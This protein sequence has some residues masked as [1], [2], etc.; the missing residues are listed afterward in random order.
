MCRPSENGSKVQIKMM[1]DFFSF[2]QLSPE[3]IKTAV[4]CYD[5]R[6]R[7]MLFMAN[8]TS[9]IQELNL[10]DNFLFRKVMGDTEI[11]RR[12]LEKILNVPI[13][14]VNFPSCDLK[15]FYGL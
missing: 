5:E 10:A 13:K 3:E 15:L 4:P 9:T 1:Y 7:G 6:K 8:I 11:C 12:V 14:T 2:V